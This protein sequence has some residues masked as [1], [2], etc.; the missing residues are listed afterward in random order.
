MDG[1]TTTATD[2]AN[3]SGYQQ[4]PMQRYKESGEC[5]CSLLSFTPAQ[6]MQ[7]AITSLCHHLHSACKLY[8]PRG[9]PGSLLN[10]V[11]V[12]GIALPCKKHRM[13]VRRGW[14]LR[15]CASDRACK[16]LGVVHVLCM[17]VLCFAYWW[18]DCVLQAQLV[19]WHMYTANI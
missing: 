13:S 6:C 2:Q 18:Y 9:I 16:G 5:S 17:L 4:M 11:Q 7:T 15:R 10:V 14:Q 8:R 1:A 19:C 12:A 3:R